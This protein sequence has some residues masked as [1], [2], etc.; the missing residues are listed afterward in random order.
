MSITMLL[1]RWRL[2]DSSVED[3][4]AA[5]L[6]PSLRAAARAQARR[7]GGAL[8]LRPTELVNEAYERLHVQQRVDWRNRS[9]FLAIAATLM[10][11]I[12]ID[13]MRARNSDKRGG[14]DVFVSLD[15]LSPGEAP[16]VRDSID[17]LALDQALTELA[18]I[19]PDAA[20]VVELRLFAGLTKE[21]VADVSGM[22]R[23]TVGRQWRFARVWLADQLDLPEL[24]PCPDVQH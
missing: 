11:R 4:L 7:F 14:E 9:H 8:T 1:D 2:G 5:Q 23:A 13:Y 3:A 18:K 17:W 24:L 20:R 15:S 12:A 21:Q 6:Y 22:S 10:R 16:A 19:Q